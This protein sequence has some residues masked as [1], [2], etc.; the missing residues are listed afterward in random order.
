MAA[1]KGPL[2]TPSPSTHRLRD[3]RLLSYRQWGDR[4]GQP[5]F[6]FHGMPGSSLQG[7]AIEVLGVEGVRVIAVD[8]PGYA[9]S[10][11]KPGRTVVDF[12]DDVAELADHLG[13]ERFAVFGV[14]AGGPYAVACAFALADRVRVAGAASLPLLFNRPE[15]L[16]I[17]DSNVTVLHVGGASDSQAPN[18]VES[19]REDPKGFLEGM[20]WLLKEQG[21]DARR[22]FEDVHAEAIREAVA[23]G[24]AGTT[25]DLLALLQ[26][27]GVQF[28]Q[29]R[30][31]VLLW[32]G[33]EDPL[34]PPDGSKY[35]A[36]AIPNARLT[37]LAGSGHLIAFE[38]LP[39]FLG[40]AEFKGQ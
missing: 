36:N 24:Q 35:L 33:E 15:A 1:R 10:D 23:Q 8:R 12:A 39:A 16:G 7:A 11:P 2:D 40:S 4:G 20:A 5:V 29:I 25:S 6:F 18:W 13:V 28:E 22:M 14:S 3:G 27:W 37:L 9:L 19:L 17:P 31:P 38:A 32:Q 30:V 26:P 34:S 21:T